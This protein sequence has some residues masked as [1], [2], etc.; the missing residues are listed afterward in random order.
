MKMDPHK[1]GKM[2]EIDGTKNWGEILK[3]LGNPASVKTS[4]GVW[5]NIDYERRGLYPR[6]TNGGG[7]FYSWLGHPTFST[8][9]LSPEKSGV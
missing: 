8:Y 6:P 7:G 5:F 1:T 9:P 4:N 2:F 3:A